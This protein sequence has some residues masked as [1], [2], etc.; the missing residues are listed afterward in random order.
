M[1]SV[2][3]LLSQLLLRGGK[4]LSD[5]VLVVTDRT[6]CDVQLKGEKLSVM[7]RVQ[8]E[9]LRGYSSCPASGSEAF[10]VH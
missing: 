1:F 5:R 6:L 10:V 4:Q 8:L 7:H 2:R 9:H 3:V